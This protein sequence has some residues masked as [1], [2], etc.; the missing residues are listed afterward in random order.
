[1]MIWLSM[2]ATRPRADAIWVNGSPVFRSDIERRRRATER[3]REQI[4]RDSRH[5]YPAGERRSAPGD[6]A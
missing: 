1:M 5:A 2:G 6:R 4:R 3:R